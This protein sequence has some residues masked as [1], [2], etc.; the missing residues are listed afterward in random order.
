LDKI[1]KVKV[2]NAAKQCSVKPTSVVVK[3]V[4]VLPSSRDTM[5]IRPAT[6]QVFGLR[7]P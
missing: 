4:L 3:G 2:S 7:I 1:S 6:N 5:P